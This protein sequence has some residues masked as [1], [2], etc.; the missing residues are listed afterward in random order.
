M[1]SRFPLPENNKPKQN[2]PFLQ[3]NSRWK[4]DDTSPT[5][6]RAPPISKR[7]GRIEEEDNNNPF[8][9]NSRR[10]TFC[11]KRSHDRDYKRQQYSEN[12]FK[13]QNRFARPQYQFKKDEFPALGKKTA[14]HN[15]LVLDF[16][17]AAVRGKDKP[18]PPHH[19]QPVIR[20]PRQP[21]KQELPPDNY[22]W[23]TDDEI[24]DREINPSDDEK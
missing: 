13:R 16:S 15:T 3:T 21:K 12:T 10:S 22:E 14:T 20:N 1:T 5:Q 11:S 7:W 4:R 23:T 24:E 8:Q 2:N 17:G 9:S 6:H 18:A 19:R